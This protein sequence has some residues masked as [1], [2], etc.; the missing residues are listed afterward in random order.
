MKSTEELSNI[1][2]QIKCKDELNSFISETNSNIDFTAYIEDIISSNS[3]TKSQVIENSGL[4]RTYAYQILQG[5]KKP[6]RDKA[7]C[8]F[9]ACK[10][11]LNQIQKGLT[12]TGNSSLYPKNPR[13]AVIIFAI[14]KGVSIIDTNHLLDELNYSILE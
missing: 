1:L 8:L 14:N 7:L 5:T 4:S 2:R 3:L 9:I 12:L 11:N 10:M 13:D 6:S